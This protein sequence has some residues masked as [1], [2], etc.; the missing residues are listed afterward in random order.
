M[1]AKTARPLA[2]LISA[3]VTF[4]LVFAAIP[5]TALA[6]PGDTGTTDIWRWLENADGSLTITGCTAPTGGLTL[7]ATLSGK[8]VWSI[9][10][11]AFSG[12]DGIT[13]ISLPTSLRY[14]GG[15][16]FQG[17]TGLT[18][19]TVPEGIIGLNEGAFSQCANLQTVSLPS[20]L[21]TM[22]RNVF[23]FCANLTSITIPDSVYTIGDSAFSRCENLA[24][25]TLPDNPLFDTIA[26]DMFWDCTKLDNVMIPSSVITISHNAF[27]GTGLTS[28]TIP[29]S[30]NYIDSS[31]FDHCSKLTT[32]TLN[33]GLSSI[34]SFAFSDCSL[35]QSISI[36]DT[37]TSVG[38]GAFQRCTV[39]E[40]A[41]LPDN[42]SF[43]TIPAYLFASCDNLDG[44]VIP[45]SITTI[46][47][48][49]FGGSGLSSI[50]I[51]AGVTTIGQAAFVDCQN[52][53]AIDVDAAN[54]NY[55]VEDGVLYNKAKTSLMA[56]P[57]RRTGQFTVPAGV[58]DIIT[59]AFFGCDGLTGVTLPEGLKTIGA[60][61]FG[62]S[63]LTDI[64]IPQSVT[65]IGDQAFVQSSNL[66]RAIVLGDSVDFGD[67]IF[68]DTA[69]VTDGALYGHEGST[70][71]AYAQSEN[72]PFR[73]LLELSISPSN[74]KIYTGGRV[75]VTPN[76]ADGT[77][78][79]DE[80]LLSR[81][82][83]EFTGL[84]PGSV[85]VTYTSDWQSAYADI[86]INAAELPATGQD[87]TAA[88]L[89]LALAIMAGGAAATLMAIRRRRQRG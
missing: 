3:L 80:N 20:T 30:V 14:I 84:K 35:L 65:T 50:K 63:G 67:M 15:N 10:A 26:P 13:S 57:A 23:Y 42:P 55:T 17:C 39:L 38:W 46:G 47:E 5:G 88:I 9:Q 59:G 12:N 27:S 69:L 58:T 79:F 64:T 2:V 51:P 62:S 49:A 28:I 25:A 85:R 82:G 66:I 87:F 36:P 6:A 86:I 45:S 8:S 21:Q 48:S 52:L 37:V 44:V 76:V 43:N 75:T 89:L 11:N 68:W 7:P 32:V 77:W 16:A 22:A 72:I 71:Q 60:A 4:A 73:L 34:G 18:G 81:N 78:N 41:L 1:K 31:A 54:P 56:F 70:A 61:A 19:I 40:S 74:G 29:P 24:S 53:T 33:D 83:N